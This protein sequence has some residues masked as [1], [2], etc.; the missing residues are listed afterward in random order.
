MGH[1]ENY[2]LLERETEGRKFLIEREM[3]REE[4]GGGGERKKTSERRN[5]RG[6]ERVL[7]KEMGKRWKK[8]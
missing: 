8:V 2:N 7:K 1:Y 4:S 6:G 3:V 5:G